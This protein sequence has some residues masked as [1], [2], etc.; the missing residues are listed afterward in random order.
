MMTDILISIS[1]EERNLLGEVTLMCCHMHHFSNQL[2][3]SGACFSIIHIIKSLAHNE[4]KC[5]RKCDE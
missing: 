2:Q 1:V 4:N 3:L 5:G